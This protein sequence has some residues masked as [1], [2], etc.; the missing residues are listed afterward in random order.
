MEAR[1]FGSK[2]SRARN[3]VTVHLAK[4][5]SSAILNSDKWPKLLRF[6]DA[7]TFRAPILSSSYNTTTFAVML[8]DEDEQVSPAVSKSSV[9]ISHHTR[10]VC[11]SHPLSAEIPDELAIPQFKLE[12]LTY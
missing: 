4:V 7:E 11:N 2:I 8:R 3:G 6:S 9:C 10:E 1:N 12:S 5:T